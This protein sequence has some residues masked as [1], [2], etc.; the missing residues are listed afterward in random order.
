M[1]NRS[2]PMG[3]ESDSKLSGKHGAQMSSM[4]DKKGE[5]AENFHTQMANSLN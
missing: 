5:K 3:K 1:A 2:Q 4:F